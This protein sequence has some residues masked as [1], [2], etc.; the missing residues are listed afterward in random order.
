[1]V[2][3]EEQDCNSSM[4]QRT[5]TLVLAEQGQSPSTDWPARP[6]TTPLE[7]NITTS[8]KD[9]IVAESYG[10]ELAMT[11]YSEHVRDCRKEHTAHSRLALLNR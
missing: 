10:A 7:L 3:W 9:N 11:L 1:M 4:V 5:E 8:M 6:S 2:L